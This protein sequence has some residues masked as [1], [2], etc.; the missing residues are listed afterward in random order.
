MDTAIQVHGMGAIKALMFRQDVMTRFEQVM[1]G[2]GAQG[3]IN[4]VLLTVAEKPEL[5]ACTPESIMLQ[6]LRAATIRLSV[7]K[8]ARQA[9]LSAKDGKADLIIGWRGIRTMA[10]RTGKFKNINVAAVFEGEQVLTDRLKGTIT[11]IGKMTSPKV[12]GRAAYFLRKDGLEH[13]LYMTVQE[14]HERAKALKPGAYNARNGF[15][16]NPKWVGAMEAKDVL[17]MLLRDWAELDPNDIAALEAE[18]D[19]VSG[20]PVSRSAVV[21]VDPTPTDPTPPA[22][23][24]GH[25]PQMST[26]GEGKVPL[27]E[28]IVR[29]AGE[30]AMRKKVEADSAQRSRLA[31]MLNAC[32]PNDPMANKRRSDA[33]FALTG[34]R[35]VDGLPGATVLAMTWCLCRV[36]DNQFFLREDVAEEVR[37]WAD[38]KWQ[39]E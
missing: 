30:L 18:S 8:S 6:A 5:Q 1:G 4:S 10:E 13:A 9:Y 22:L 34:Y 35:T 23:S 37:T 20:D 33:L 2:R 11:I 36:N 17:V 21:D 28:R 27:K 29:K 39:A 31:M 19:T 26:F 14:I 15:W 16:Q 24:T 12:I 3:F 38:E 25:P 32:F 7:D